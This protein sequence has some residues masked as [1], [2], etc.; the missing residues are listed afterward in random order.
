LRPSTALN[1]QKV[2]FIHN[3]SGKKVAKSEENKE[4]DKNR[5][6]LLNQALNQRVQ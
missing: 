3:L 2:A 5:R 1:W 6:F 4:K